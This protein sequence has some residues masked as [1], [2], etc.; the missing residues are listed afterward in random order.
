MVEDGRTRVM[1]GRPDRYADDAELRSL[2]AAIVESSTDAIIAVTLDGVVTSWNASA[3]AIYGYSAEEMIGRH[4]SVVYPPDRIEELAPILDQIRRGRP[5]H[6]YETK[7][8][9]KDGTVIDVSISTSPVRD[10][11]GG[12]VGAAGVSRDV[13]ERNWAEAG[14]RADEARHRE[15]ERMETEARLV[16]GIATEFSSLL[17]AIMGYAASVADATAGDP[18]AQAD[19]QQIQAAA[20]SAAR[21]ARE[22]LLFGRR[23][24]TRP[25][26]IDLNALLTG[27]RGL[28]LAS[29]GADI[30]LRLI[31]TPHLPIVV[32]DRGQIGQMLLN[33]AVN[34]REAMPRGGIVTFTT[35]AADP[36]EAHPAAWLGARP[37]RCAKL[38]VSDTGHGMD[39]ETVSHAFEPF[40][41]T[42]PPDRGTGLGLSVVY[43]IVT[44]AGGAITIDSEEGRGTTFHIYL[45]AAHDPAQVSPPG[46]CLGAGQSILVVD[47]QPAVVE[48]ASRI[49]HHNGYRTLQAGSYDE[50]LSLLSTYDPDLLLTDRLLAA[51]P[52]QALADR[53]RRLK[54]GIRVLYMSGSPPPAPEPGGGRVQVLRKPFTAQDLLEKVHAALAATPEY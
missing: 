10:R 7:R 15:A 11:S 6:H 23:E 20:G 25:E 29:I 9:R 47:D 53:A 27:A 54:P 48:I 49:L 21:L 8:V 16:G 4:A 3:E 37:R 19:V 30:E 14:R 52:R 24:P 40:F 1:A 45:P 50:A 26:R 22:L 13:T 46:K 32:A 43:G 34:A 41:S 5:V 38:T 33:L 35:G 44:K 39:A 17:S 18:R 2:L 12:V 28:L 36:G 51:V 42:R 31:T